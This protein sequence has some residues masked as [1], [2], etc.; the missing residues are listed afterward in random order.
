MG[1]RG[2]T[3]AWY[4]Y[5]QGV[6]VLDPGKAQ[7]VVLISSHVY[8]VVVPIPIAKVGIIGKVYKAVD[9]VDDAINIINDPVG[10]IAGK[11]VGGLGKKKETGSY[12]NLHESGKR[13]HGKGNKARSQ[14]S[15]RERAEKN[16]DPHVGTEWKPAENDREAFEDEARRIEADGGVDN[17]MNYNEINSPGKKYLEEDG[18]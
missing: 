4:A 1:G 17:P 8:L 5:G 3:V 14:G 15:G 10:G 13:Y 12:T 18:G 7:S 11:A 2:G 16:D 6:P 9:K